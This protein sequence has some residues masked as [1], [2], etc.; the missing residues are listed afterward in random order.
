MTPAEQIHAFALC[1]YQRDDWVEIRG[2]RSGAVE[3]SW[4]RAQDLAGQ[5]ERL[6]RLNDKGLN[7]YVGP[8]PRRDEGLSG[9]AN[10]L[11]GRTVFADFDG[12]EPGDGLGPD[13]I[14]AA[15]IADAGLPVP[16]LRL[17]SGHGV[18]AYWRLLEPLA[19]DAWRG[20]Q[21]RL[22]A[23]LA[24]DR[25]IKN[26]ERLMR[27]PGFRNVK[28]EPYTD[29]FLLDSDWQ[30]RYALADLAAHLHPASAPATPA[31]TSA[32][33]ARARAERYAAKWDPCT[34]GERNAAAYRHAAQVIRDFALPDADAWEL[35]R[36]WN[37]GNQ[38]PLDERELHQAFASAKNHAR[39]PLGAKLHRAIEEID[40]DFR[41]PQA[42]EHPAET[43]E[44][45]LHATIAGKRTAIPWPWPQLSIL[46]KALL[47]GTVTLLGGGVGA[48]KSF[49][50]L[51]AMLFWIESGV[52]V[53]LLVLE[54]DT[55]H[56]LVRML[57]QLEQRA[58]LT[59]PDWVKV[60]PDEVN[61]AFARHRAFIDRAGASIWDSP[62]NEQT[63]RGVAEWIE[64]RAAEDYRLICVDPIT[65]TVQMPEP[66]LHD[67][68][69]INRVKRI[70]RAHG[71]SIILITHG[72]KGAGPNVDVDSLAGSAAYGRFAQTVLWLECHEDK[73]V[74]TRQACGT[75]L[76]TANRTL[77]ILKARN[78]RG[79]G[80]RLACR[81]HS[82]S[83]TLSELG[84][85]VRRSKTP[86]EAAAD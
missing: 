5:A 6:Q 35:L 76:L 4:V 21:E 17:C 77:H 28:A 57:A 15:R 80:V 44:E 69:F 12:L 8:N 60:H 43:V 39:R 59:D 64:Q 41:P 63:L 58:E 52:K 36:A 66:W 37:R 61:G 54:E 31:P 47:G 83:L 9:D 3:K 18:H 46:T 70:A 25:A 11:C 78:G 19:P 84:I 45:L 2:L 82:D 13:E 75:A 81:F 55:S 73:T 50:L 72:R 38:P 67:P 26:P 22:N 86:V 48:S 62:A 49:Q 14:V 53:A 7:I 16:T 30:R 10:V 33:E 27:L 71:V 1:V 34:L 85:I 23:T 40:E 32:A 65:A 20:I 51:Q 79:T 42:P 24:S 68:Q 29:C 56:C 74:A